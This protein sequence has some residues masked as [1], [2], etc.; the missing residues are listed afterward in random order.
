MLKIK[1]KQVSN[2]YGESKIKKNRKEGE[3]LSQLV[4]FLLPGPLVFMGGSVAPFFGVVIQWSK[5]AV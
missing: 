2:Y 3:D 1:V 4:Q 5:L